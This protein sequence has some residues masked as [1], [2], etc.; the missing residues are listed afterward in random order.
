M[1]SYILRQLWSVIEETQASV[2]L[3]L[4]D[5]ELVKQVLSQ[6]DSRNPLTNDEITTVSGYLHSR[7]SLIR[8]LA[9]AR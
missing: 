7:T 2:L 4:N 3:R 1:N 6:L 9:L 5:T 8:D